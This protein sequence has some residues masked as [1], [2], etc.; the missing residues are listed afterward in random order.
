MSKK[1]TK[2][3]SIPQN[4]PSGITYLT[5]NEFSPPSLKPP[6]PFQFPLPTLK[7]PNHPFTSSNLLPISPSPPMPNPNVKIKKL[8]DGHPAY[9]GYGLFANKDLK[10]C[11]M[12]TC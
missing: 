7:H 11:S 9:P 1:Y 6:N 3:I 4:W 2:S 5:S 12:V 8:R 10:K